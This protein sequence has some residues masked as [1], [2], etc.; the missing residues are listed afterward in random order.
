LQRSR[1]V[2]LV[3]ERITTGVPQHVRMRFKAELGLAPRPFDHACEP[4]GA[5]GCAALR[6]E[7][8]GRPRLLL[9]LEPPECPQL[10][11]KDWVGA[12]RTLFHPADVKRS[13]GKLNLVPAQIDQFG[14]ELLKRRCCA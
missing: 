8:E 6:C 11:P 14:L 12:G 10:V 3:C 4:G 2:S 1:V 13:R 7:Y 5:E 9:T